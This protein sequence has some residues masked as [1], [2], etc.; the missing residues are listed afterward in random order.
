MTG[1]KR[2]LASLL[3]TTMLSASVMPASAQVLSSSPTP[4]ERQQLTNGYSEDPNRYEIYPVPHSAVYPEGA[5]SFTM[6]KEVNVV[7]ESGIG[8][9][10]TAFLEEILSDYD[11]T[12]TTSASIVPGKT[13]IL[14]GIYKDADHKVQDPTP[15]S[16]ADLFEETDSTGKGKYDPYMLTVE[17]KDNPN[18]VITIVGKDDDC[19]YYGLA[20]LQMMFTSFAGKKFLPVQIE[21][22]SNVIFRG[23]IEGFYGDFDYLARESQMRSIRDVKGNIYVFASK[24]DRYHAEDWHKLYPDDELA[25]IQNLVNVGR[26]T[27]VDYAW[28]VHIG[29]GNFFKDA[30]S[31]PQSGAAYTKYLE[32]VDKLKKKFQQLYNVGVRNFQILN[33]DYNSGTD[34]D[35][36][37]LLN[38]MNGWLKEKN[39]CGP[40]IYCPKK[41]NIGW[42]GDGA[43]LNALRGLDDDI[44]IYWTGSDVNSPINQHNITWPYEKSGQYPVTWLNY[45]CS[46]HDKSGLYLGDISHYV[47]KADGLM[48]QMGIISNPV[49]YPEA[50]KVAYFQLI[51]WGWNR[52]NYTSYMNELWEDCFKYLQPEVYDAYLTIARNVSNCPDS[53][54]IPQGF[55]ESEYLKDTLNSVQEKALSGQLTPDDPELTK[56]MDEYAH[57]LS[58]VEEF[59]AK[60]D[61]DALKVELEPWLKSLSG[62]VTAGQEAL[63]AVLAIQ[64]EDVNGAWTHLSNASHGLS[65]W[66]R[67]P[68]PQYAD[69]MAK[70]GSKRLQPFANKLISYVEEK[71]LPILS[72]DGGLSGNP[73]FYAVLGGNPQ[74][75]SP[76]S[77]K[78]F[79]GD[80]NTFADFEVDQKAGDYVGVD[81]GTVKTIRSIDIL[82]GKSDTHHD[83]MHKTALECSVDGENWVTL[84]DKVNS[85]HIQAKDLNL[86][87]RYVRLR[88]LETGY[89]STAN[90]WTYVREFTVHTDSDNDSPIYTS[91]DS[92]DGLSVTE[93]GGVYTLSAD[94]ALTLKPDDYVGIRLPKVMGIKKISWNGDLPNGLAV[95]SS[96][97][98][99]VWQDGAVNNATPIRYIRLVNQ[100]G[101]AY[102]G[103]IP[104][105][106]AT[107]SATE[108]KLS[109]VN[110]NMKLH[111]GK[112]EDMI[113]GNPAS[114]VWTN[115]KQA[116]GQ[117]VIFDLGSKQ[118]VHD[119]KLAFPENGDY[120]H[121]LDISI[122]NST[123]PQGEWTLIGDFD[124]NPQMSPPYRYYTCDGGGKSARYIK[125]EI[126]KAEGGWIKFNELEVNK[127]VDQGDIVGAFS[128][129]PKGDFEKM[130]DGNITSQFSTGPI[131]NE[132]GYMQYLISDNKPISEITI[133]QSPSAISNATVKV[134]T[135]DEN[136]VDLGT[137]DQGVCT[138]DTSKLGT[139]LALR[140]DWKSGTSPAIAEIIL[141]NGT[142][143][144]GQPSG[145]IP[146]RYPNI[147]EP[148]S[149]TLDGISVNYGTKE[150]LVGLP[151]RAQITLSNGHTMQ[152]P[153]TWTCENYN[154]TQAGDY[155]FIGTY[156]L[157]DTT[158]N[159]GLFSLKTTVTVRPESS[160]PDTP[161]EENLALQKTVYVSG[162]EIPNDTGAA[163]AVDGNPA[164]RWSSNMMKGG[165]TKQDAWIVVDLQENVDKIASISMEYFKKVWPVN[166]VV[167]VAG[168][169]FTP[170]DYS[171]QN[172][173]STIGAQDT[174]TGDNTK[175]AACW[176]T[177]A[178]FT[179]LTHNDDPTD[180]VSSS[181]F[182]KELPQ[183]TRYIRLYFT[184]I[185]GTAIGNAIGLEELTVT[186]TRGDQSHAKSPN[187]A[188]VKSLTASGI[189]GAAFNT[190]SL[191]QFAIAQLADGT[192]VRLPVKW[193]D[194]A[195]DSNLESQTLEGTLLVDDTEITNTN[196]IKAQ[197]TLTLTATPA[198]GSVLINPSG[199]TAASGA[200]FEALGLPKQTVVQLSN[201]TVI[202]CDIEWDKNTYHPDQPGTQV[203]QGALSL[204]SEVP[205]P[206]QVK[207]EMPVS[208]KNVTNMVTVSFNSNGGT[209]VPA[210]TIKRGEVVSKPIAPTRPDYE[211]VGWYADAALTQ[212]WDFTQ[213]VNSNM[214]LYAKWNEVQHGSGGGSVG[215]GGSSGSGGSSSE[216]DKST[217]SITVSKS[218]HGT[219]TTS[220]RKASS[221][222]LVTITV[223]PNEGYIL[224]S[225][226]VTD[227]NGQNVAATEE[228]TGKYTFTMPNTVVTINATFTAGTQDSAL[229]FTDTDKNS[230]FY[231]SVKYVYNKHLMEGTS[232]NTFAP[233][234]TTNR[235]MLVTILWRLDGKPQSNAK[236]QFTDVAQDTWYTDPV[237]WAADHGIVKGL[238][239]TL[240]AP[241]NTITREQL[242]AIFYRYAEQ[243]NY[244]VTSKGDLSIFT[245]G[246]KTS[247][248]AVPAMEWAVGSGLLSGKGGNVLDP[249]GTAT[250]AEIAAILMRFDKL[251][252]Q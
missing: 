68:T 99:V 125:L 24:F 115:A 217:H 157:D 242:A 4:T 10:T 109:F 233:S 182:I 156:H 202:A 105:L 66:N 143:S 74:G 249:T 44:Y 67:Y 43:E 107:L 247:S 184:E 238:S 124:N 91:L 221:G 5:A 179:G 87:A 152:L 27:K 134:Q 52:D 209:S 161:T 53:G 213:P 51:S 17:T 159:P 246:K 175:D 206:N 32:N 11:M 12:M 108:T 232:A 154:P 57:I 129:N 114:F 166:Y 16:R 46:E 39:D 172:V 28:S 146:L 102:T 13:N 148:Q 116:P 118:P 230:W 45:P 25:Q 222:Q 19:V 155:Q 145:T 215:G 181:D 137:L 106:S 153:V 111:S 29:K 223:K 3:T 229:P 205:N 90:F 78:M 97:N 250:R 187:V 197:L 178:E 228:S 170:H 211:F 58:A 189:Q 100:S 248:Y 165:T 244:N 113:D 21:D 173:G 218:D 191:P 96:A 144:G 186:G 126:S 31:S 47:S 208:V 50:N 194:T 34:A 237:R 210:Q 8:S 176:T 164:T 49:D 200:A 163:M 150:T 140:L 103:N 204:P 158:T 73:S 169:N 7:V 240:F 112:W 41:Y 171:K 42:A 86:P 59:R 60:C 185:N 149:T 224:D 61:N 214:T 6:T 168:S 71:L 9:Y 80:P 131:E 132:S 177:V 201:G 212:A 117:Y 84:A 138:F 162:V 92:T 136:W 62:I 207:A 20:S 40:I 55:P 63:Q 75:D 93:D 38:H 88:L 133:L 251:Y 70:A 198:V 69:K 188:T 81:L 241:N 234:L 252:R 15:T 98:G 192:T 174:F 18:G 23:F 220:P 183:G 56:L 167:Q 89:G 72:P 14:L 151:E 142:G 127:N 231:E 33:D 120:P 123:D 199:L 227:K 196:Q 22:Y 64:N 190:L 147:Y 79:D 139:L 37:N 195:Y 101:A 141:L 94:N 104:A 76:K 180:T 203:V 65:E 54:R 225:L 121:F 122:G 160:N 82:Q 35:V 235:S 243:K 36:V 236:I 216:S 219:V 83:Y 128:G 193:N 48:N 239:D 30:S 135:A 85:H 226:T 110:T 119:V 95:Q 1:K 26:E 2:V 130:M 245:D 77:A